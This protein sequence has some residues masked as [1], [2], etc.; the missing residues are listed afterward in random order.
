MKEQKQDPAPREQA[1]DETPDRQPDEVV[2]ISPAELESALYPPE[3]ATKT[4]KRSKKS[5]NVPFPK[6]KKAERSGEGFGDA[7]GDAGPGFQKDASHSDQGS[8]DADPERADAARRGIYDQHDAYNEHDARDQEEKGHDHK[9]HRE[10][11]LERL[12][13]L[14]NLVEEKLLAGA[15]KPSVADWIRLT[16]FERELMKTNGPREVRVTWVTP[17]AEDVKRV[18]GPRKRSPKDRQDAA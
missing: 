14:I 18:F 5:T 15:S 9:G 7:S 13:K 12:D 2:S 6:G 4:G 17:T 1:L 16:E 11:R 3:V 10:S 8:Q